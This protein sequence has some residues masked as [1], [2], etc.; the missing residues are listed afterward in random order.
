M[1]RMPPDIVRN[2]V[3]HAPGAR[4]AV[5]KTGLTKTGEEIVPAVDLRQRAPRCVGVAQT[6]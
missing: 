4:T 5:S 6:S 1:V 2:A 3:P